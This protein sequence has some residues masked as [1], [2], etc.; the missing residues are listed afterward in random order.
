MNFEGKDTLKPNIIIIVLDCV[1]HDHL[2]CAGSKDVKTPAIDMIASEGVRFTNAVC[3]A[4]FTTPSIT[5]ILT[6][7][8]PFNHG[9][10]LLIGQHLTQSVPTASDI[11]R[12]AGYFTAGFPSVFLFDKKYGLDR[13]FDYYDDKI[14]T[15]RKGFRGP[16]RPG[17]LT[18]D[19]VIS[20]LKDTPIDN[21]LFLFI[22]YF[23][24]H[25]YSAGHAGSLIK[26]QKKIDMVD[27]YVNR[28]ISALEEYN[29]WEDTIIVITGDHG[30]GFG[31][32]GLHGHGKAL[33]D[34]LLRVPLIIRAPK[35]IRSGLVV[36]QQVRHI[37]IFPTLL[38]LIG[39]YDDI[40]ETGYR[41]DGVSL[42]PAI[43]GK[44]LDLMSYAETSP[45]QLFTGDFLESKEFKGVEMMSLRTNEKKYI[46]KTEIFN[47][48]KY[49]TWIKKEKVNKFVKIFKS[50]NVF[51]HLEKEEFYDLKSDPKETHNLA[52]KKPHI[53][54]EFKIQLDNLIQ[55]QVMREQL[56]IACQRVRRRFIR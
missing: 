15:I 56:K 34:E 8:Y 2:G 32:H 45:I 27:T 20:F 49:R 53:C 38:D 3:Q 47:P 39:I 37:D 1:R 51:P 18:T 23:D 42:M 22:H 19:S 50:H 5:S 4:P 33:Y 44:N 46:Y 31:E 26:Y 10:Q 17:D 11:F 40:Q 28:L 35:L 48:D 41:F 14:E 36:D 43:V 6:G 52:K 29:L 21:P 24:A 13:G 9:I 54:K 12:E 16:W 30:D 55:N 25:D 7:L